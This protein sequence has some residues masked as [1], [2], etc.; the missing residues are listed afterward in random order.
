MSHLK[1]KVAASQLYR[2]KS[3]PDEPTVKT[4]DTSGS[5]YTNSPLEKG[6][7]KEENSINVKSEPI[8]AVKQEPLVKLEH[9]SSRTA[10]KPDYQSNRNI[11]KNYSRAMI[12]FALSNVALPH[13]SQISQEE[14]VNLNEFKLFLKSQKKAVNSIKTLRDLLL[15]KKDEDIKIAAFK[16]VF[17]KISEVFVKFFSINWIFHSK[18]SDR[19]MHVKY[20]FKI[21]R[22]I[23][24]PEYFTYLENFHKTR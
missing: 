22:R 11:V 1:S 14:F 23:R 10:N 3:A 15:I 2:V 18:I 20:R 21:L 6:Q 19:M 8:Y 16:R 4:E 17:G 12:N 9:C 7:I 13:L 5:S 24:N